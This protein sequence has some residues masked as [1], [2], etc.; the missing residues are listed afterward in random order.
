M[1]APIVATGTT[2]ALTGFVARITSITPP[3]ISRE[4]LETSHLGSVDW[5]E[6]LPGKLSDGGEFGATIQFDPAV[7]PPLNAPDEAVI[8]FPDGETMTFDCFLTNYAP[9]AD[10]ETIMTATVTFKVTGPV[11]FAAAP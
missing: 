8:T 6:F 5:K 11:V 10:L 3:N 1:P 4:S 2:V 9:A 7:N